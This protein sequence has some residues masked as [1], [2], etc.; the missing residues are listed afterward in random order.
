MIKSIQTIIVAA[1]LS[2]L[3]G[4]QTNQISGRNQFVLV[5]EKMAINESRSAYSAMLQPLSQEGKVNNDPAMVR[6]VETITSRLVAQ[7]IR[8]RPESKDWD[9]SIRVIN[10]P[11]TVNAWCMAGGRMAIY[12]G[13][14]NKLDA[15]DDEIAMVM[16]HEISHA[17]L[18]HTRE[19]MSRAIAMNLGVQALA[20]AIDGDRYGGYIVQGTALAA[21]VALE[22][23]NSRTAEAESDRIGIEIAAKAGYD[24]RAAASLWEKM[25]KQSGDK[26]SRFD[27]FSTHPAPV[28][29]METLRELAVPLMPFF[30]DKSPKPTHPINT[31]L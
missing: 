23:P 29:R 31:G 5:S 14:I 10:E 9:W 26:D 21:I 6:R 13:L 3:V 8:Y 19:R 20:I 24:P 16:G 4:C 1:V 25:A 18:S 17:L 12:T 30:E 22:L 2:V 11:D 15:T 28:K 27:F 7:A